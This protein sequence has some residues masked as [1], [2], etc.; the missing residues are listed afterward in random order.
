MF[1]VGD[2]SAMSP[3]ETADMFREIVRQTQ[4]QLSFKDQLSLLPYAAKMQVVLGAT[5]GMSPHETTDTTLAFTHLFRQ[6][7]PKGIPGMMDTV[8]KMNELMPSDPK[9]ALRQMT[10]FE[11]LFKSLNIPDNLAA[12]YMVFM[13]RA[14]LATGKGGT[15]ARAMLLQG[16]GMLQMTE[17]AQGG[18]KKLLEQMGL[19]DA[20][21]NSPF[22]HDKGGQNGKGYFDALAMDTQ[23]ANYAKGDPKA[24]FKIFSALGMQGG[25]IATLMADPVLIKALKQVADLMAHQKSLGLNAQSNTIAANADFAMKRGAKDFQALAT[26][27]GS[28]A[29]P[30]ITKGFNDMGTA[31]HGA[32][33]WLHQHPDIMKNVQKNI[34]D[35][36]A[37]IERFLVSHK[38][39]WQ[40]F[41]WRLYNL[42][43]D[44][45]KL[46]PLLEVIAN[47]FIAIGSAL[48]PFLDLI[49][50]V[51]SVSKTLNPEDPGYHKFDWSKAAPD[52][53]TWWHSVTTSHPPPGSPAYIALH[54]L[55]GARVVGGGFGP[56]APIGPPTPHRQ[57][58]AT[59]GLTRGEGLA[60]LHR[61]ELVINDSLTKRLDRMTRRGTNSGANVNITLAP[62]YVAAP[63]ESDGTHTRRSKRM[64]RE[65]ANQVAAILADQLGLDVHAGG[66]IPQLAGAS[67]FAIV[68]ARRAS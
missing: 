59:G 37:G 67:H 13:S 64:I 7:D 29:L 35:D 8:L 60:Y 42:A 25:N 4:G 44:A 10:Y 6:Y 38:K 63:G 12:A 21:G 52:L 54:P 18:K 53:K 61:N 20:H 46:G 23:I 15:G 19:L 22:W 11:P 17:H 56:Q 39:D 24:V 49:H 57:K 40:E 66:A 9:Q 33:L 68:G 31:L 62:T 27:I 55:A 28:Y 50:G 14:G 16:T 58:L 1:D 32:Q 26:E 51:A 48:S 47:G 41:G 43:G 3:V 34:T 30:G 45:Q 65:L 5:R 36:V 2:T